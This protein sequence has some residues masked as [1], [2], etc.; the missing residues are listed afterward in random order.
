METLSSLVKVSVPNYL[1]SLPI[2]N[3]FG[4]WFKLGCM[5]CRVT[6]FTFTDLECP[7]L[8]P[9]LS[10]HVSFT[11][12]DW[13]SLIPPTALVAGLGYTAYRAFH[14]DGRPTSKRCNSLIRMSEGKVV[15][16]VDVEDI[17]EKASFCRCWKSKNVSIDCHVLHLCH[18][19]S[20]VLSSLPVAL[21][22]RSPRCP[23][24]GYGRQ[25][26][27]SRCQ[28]QAQGI[29]IRHD[30]CGRGSMVRWL[31]TRTTRAKCRSR[32]SKDDI[33]THSALSFRLG[34]DWW[35]VRFVLFY[36]IIHYCAGW[37]AVSVGG[38]RWPAA[39]IPL[40]S[41]LYKVL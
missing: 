36:I 5:C 8:W 10:H 20:L 30:S 6:H 27:T 21:L 12:K 22:R 40:H 1:S 4:G 38:R 37:W 19:W 28:A 7:S 11:V 29:M 24:Q 17:A 9:H 34:N 35:S 25:S 39:Y 32:R 18:L 2:P 3:S 33:K 13:L 15:D 14:P 16:F 31:I 26:R 23:Q 41:K